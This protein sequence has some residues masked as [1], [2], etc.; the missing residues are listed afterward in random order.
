VVHTDALRKMEGRSEVLHGRRGAHANE[1]HVAAGVAVRQNSPAGE[2][3]SKAR[4]V[5]A[6][7]AE[8]VAE[9]NAALRVL[10]QVF[11]IAVI[12]L[13]VTGFLIRKQDIFVPAEGWGYVLGIAGGVSMLLL[14]LY[15]VVKRVA[16]L[17]F[18]EHSVFWLRAHMVLGTAGPLLIFFHSNFSLGA[19]NSNIALICMI[20]VALSGVA[21]RYIYTRVHRGLSAVRFDLNTLLAS[22][23]RLLAMI[24]EDTGGN[25][26]LIAK[27]MADF[28]AAAIA[29][30]RD[31]MTS[32][33]T[34]MMLPLRVSF[35]RSSMMR[36][37]RATLARNTKINGWPR[38]ERGERLRHARQHVNEFLYFASRASQLRFWEH[39]FS[40][41]HVLHVPL[42]FVLLVSGVVHVV[43]V[44]LY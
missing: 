4:P 8:V 2:A 42:F 36:E 41:W 7:A 43:A 28:A 3:L 32:L 18:Q 12:S 11:T 35:A 27:H 37:V 21:G 29:S 40:L 38:A 10:A 9:A 19:T 33:W 22:S 15:P 34:A 26:A 24:G 16:V 13:L 30:N 5:P 1:P 39:M 6:P 20:L 23:S 44:H 14:L 17:G 25:N 31:L